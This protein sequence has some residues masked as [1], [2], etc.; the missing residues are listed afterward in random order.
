MNTDPLP[1]LFLKST[2]PPLS[3]DDWYIPGEDFVS[4]Y[5]RA[6]N[7]RTNAS[8][9]FKE[10]SAIYV[11]SSLVGRRFFFASLPEAPIFTENTLSVGGKL[12]NMW[13]IL[14]G[15]S[16]ISRK[17]T[18][19]KK[20]LELF[21]T[22]EHPV[23]A[24]SFSPEA[25]ISSLAEL[26]K[27]K[28]EV[29][30]TLIID[31]ASGFFSEATKRNSY[32]NMINP[33]LS[34][35]YDGRVYERITKSQG[36]ETIPNPYL[37]L[38]MSSSEFLPGYFN[39]ECL[40]QGFLNRFC[41]VFGKD[42]TSNIPKSP[43]PWYAQDVSFIRN[44]AK[45]LS[46]MP[47]DRRVMLDWSPQSSARSEFES[48]EQSIDDLIETGQLGILKEGYYGAL[49]NLIERLASI[50]RIS[51]SDL[52]LASELLLIESQ[53]LNRALK[54][55]DEVLVPSFEKAMA[56][57]QKWEGKTMVNFD[58]T[59]KWDA[60]LEKCKTPLSIG[61]LQHDTGISKKF[62]YPQI[63]SLFEQGRIFGLIGK[64]ITG[65]N[66][67]LLLCNSKKTLQES[68]STHPLKDT[69]M[70]DLTNY[71]KFMTIWGKP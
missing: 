22:V 33:I 39:D 32:L 44:Y 46:S 68:L 15:K 40:V 7:C 4:R 10:A 25:L 21:E 16:R 62:L 55:K 36:K 24:E 66:T 61:Q 43:P 34:R 51:R 59:P 2:D 1:P 48:F 17:T 53:D 54:F 64:P 23:L 42:H 60:I 50:Y 27:D 19:I 14:I 5:V 29:V 69:F 57:K 28:Q 56:L 37:N 12:L 58:A 45:K 6:L 9:T 13:F 35:L 3:Q 38:F 63:E 41:F 18:I 30:A 71:G 47:A 31:E 52:N 49:P 26:G 67:T 11:L 65:G 70:Y 8:L 20:M